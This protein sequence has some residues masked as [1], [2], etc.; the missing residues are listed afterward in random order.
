MRLARR[1]RWLTVFVTVG[2]LLFGQ[3]VLANYVCP[4]SN[5]ATAMAQMREAGMP[6]AETMSLA[7]DDVQPG[8]CHAHCQ[9]T[10]QSADS[11]QVPAFTSVAELGPVLTLRVAAM[12]SRAGVPE[13]PRAA[14]PPQSWP[15][16]AIRNC[17]LRT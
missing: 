17:C 3:L 1:N 13:P 12:D 9:A 5:N 16:L 7:L 15:S 4:A 6:C 8:L 14:P 11:Y 10:Q 2:A